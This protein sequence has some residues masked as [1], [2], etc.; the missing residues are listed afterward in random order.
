MD[1]ESL[2]A[3]VRLT[4]GMLGSA[5]IESVDS[6]EPVV[7][8]RVPLG[9]EVVG[10][11][12]YAAVFSHP[13][14]PGAVVKA[15]APGRPGIEAEVLVYRV[16]GEHPSYSRCLHAGPNYLILRRLVGVTLFECLRRG[17]PV[18]PGAI[19]SIDAALDAARARGLFP[20]DVHAKNVMIGPAGEGLVVDVS[21]FG[22][23]LPCRR[24]DDIK[25][26]YYMLYQPFMAWRPVPIPLW[27]LDL[28]RRGYRRFAFRSIEKPRASGS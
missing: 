21:D 17:M 23:E 24:W 10:A 9:W 27:I 1:V 5:E 12:N 4:E 13:A 19:R 15:Y 7:V 2:N 20:H 26:A 11:G 6:G 14:F 28:V 3:L 18:P 8:H 16:L 25:R 22:H